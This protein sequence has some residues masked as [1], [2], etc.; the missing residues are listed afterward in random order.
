MLKPKNEALALNES[1]Q[2]SY[3]VGEHNGKKINGF[4]YN[5][6]ATEFMGVDFNNK[7]IILKT[8]SG[9]KGLLNN[10]HADTV[11]AVSFSNALATG[12]YLRENFQKKN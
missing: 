5:N 10:F 9:T 8:S 11:L 4:H 1:I 2:N 12:L 3:L 7:T 6:S